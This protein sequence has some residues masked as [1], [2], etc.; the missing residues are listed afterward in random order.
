MSKENR[1]NIAE[2]RKAY[3][4]FFIIEKY[5]AGIALTGTEIKS[6]RMGRVTMNDCFARVEK[7]QIYLYNLHISPYTHGNRY[8]HEPLRTRKLLLHKQEIMKL[9]GKTQEKGFSL[10]AL[11][12]Y[13]SGDWAK[14]ELGL[15]KG[16]K[17]YDKRD[18]IKERD[19]KREIG[20]AMRKF[21]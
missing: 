10:V 5:E 14:V 6:I 16:K 7:G 17:E 3:H 19:S 13:W 21:V 2:N 18:A 4:D 1:K 11:K 12:L 9:F 15:V 8:N 20:R